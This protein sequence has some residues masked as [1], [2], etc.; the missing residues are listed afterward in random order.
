MGEGV[1]GWGGDGGRDRGP[2]KRPRPFGTP[3]IL[4]LLPAPTHPPTLAAP[5]KDEGEGEGG[6]GGWVHH[7]TVSG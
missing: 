6:Y 1:Q 7:E 5:G 3:F 4:P 2:P